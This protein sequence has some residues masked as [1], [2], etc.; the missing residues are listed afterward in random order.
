MDL[1]EKEKIEIEFWKNSQ[2]ENPD[3]FSLANFLNKTE[4]LKTLNT[5]INNHLPHFANA[6]SVLEL[7]A[8]Q[9]WASAFM[10]RWI[11]PN[12]AI[13]VTDISPYAV[14]SVKYWEEVFNVELDG[15]VACKSYNLTFEDNKFDLVFCYAAAHHFVKLEESLQEIYRVLKPSGKCVFLYEPTCSKLFYKMH[16][17]YVNRQRPEIPEDVLIPKE[18]IKMG[19]KLNFQVEHHYDLK[20]QQTQSIGMSLYFKFISTFSFL[21]RLLPS[22][23]DFIFIKTDK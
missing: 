9:G 21:Q 4:H 11:I 1:K 20:S 3:S 22:S 17:N 2:H 7:G 14:K 23:S 13:T 12:A 5:K 19:Q 10:K 6:A 15:A 16:F 8:G 18:L